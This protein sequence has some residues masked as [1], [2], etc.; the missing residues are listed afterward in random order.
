[1]ELFSHVMQVW[2]TSCG[3][4]SIGLGTRDCI[5]RLPSQ[6]GG[7]SDLYFEGF[8]PA[9]SPL[10]LVAVGWNWVRGSV[11]GERELGRSSSNDS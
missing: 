3:T 6:V 7:R 9:A 8:D 1:M 11:D 4:H 5:E 2:Y 10:S